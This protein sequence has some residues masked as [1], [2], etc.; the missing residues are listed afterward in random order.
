MD[1]D[2]DTSVLYSLTEEEEKQGA[3]KKDEAKDI[4]VLNAAHFLVFAPFPDFRANNYIEEM[5]YIPHFDVL[6]PPPKPPLL[7]F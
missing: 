3:D 7:I 6:I 4:V 1:A 5:Q 2:N